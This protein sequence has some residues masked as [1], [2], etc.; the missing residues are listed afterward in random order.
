MCNP[1]FDYDKGELIIQTSDNTG[2][3][4]DGHLVTRVGD[5]MAMD[6]DS[7]E[8]HITSSWNDEDD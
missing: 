6:L 2:I 8:L 7:G 1:I 4:T 3:T 5:N